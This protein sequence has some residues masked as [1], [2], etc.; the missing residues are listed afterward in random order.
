MSEKAFYQAVINDDKGFAIQNG[1][2]LPEMR[3]E[4]L[5]EFAKTLKAFCHFVK[6]HC[7]IL[8][9]VVESKARFE[10]E[11]QVNE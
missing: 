7:N 5:T 2:K 8:Y 10:Q 1:H 11:H 3:Y 9:D 6:L 4:P